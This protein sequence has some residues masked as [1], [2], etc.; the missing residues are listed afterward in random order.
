MTAFCGIACY[1]GPSVCLCALG[2]PLAADKYTTP[3]NVSAYLISISSTRLVLFQI[4]RRMDHVDVWI[5]VD[6][7]GNIYSIRRGVFASN[8]VFN[9]EKTKLNSDWKVCQGRFL[10]N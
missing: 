2:I 7:E 4:V 8:K 9:E 1:V 3:V 6:I 10:V 5:R